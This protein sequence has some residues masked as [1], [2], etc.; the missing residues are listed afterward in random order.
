MHHAVTRDSF[1]REMAGP[2]FDD[3]REAAD[4]AVQVRGGGAKQGYQGR[5][6]RY[7]GRDGGKAGVSVHGWMRGGGGGMFRG[8]RERD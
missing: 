3:V 2:D 5:G 7:K 6:I 1:F 8:G 4:Q